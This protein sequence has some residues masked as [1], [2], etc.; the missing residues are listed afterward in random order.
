MV[1]DTSFVNTFSLFPPSLTS[2]DPLRYNTRQ[3]PN[4]IAS[5]ISI[6]TRKIENKG[7]VKNAKRQAL[8]YETILVKALLQYLSSISF[9]ASSECLRRAVEACNTIQNLV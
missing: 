9:H 3:N 6:F 7:F 4:V 1:G 8:E 5:H 2:Y